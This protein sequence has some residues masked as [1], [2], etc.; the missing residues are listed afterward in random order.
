MKSRIFFNILL[1]CML[2]DRIIL[3]INFGPS[4]EFL[5][6]SFVFL[7]FFNFYNLNRR[8]RNEM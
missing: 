8:L 2:F 6:I 5:I 4:I 7:T 1:G 3:K